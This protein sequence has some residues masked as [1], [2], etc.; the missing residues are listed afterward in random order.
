MYS[1]MQPFFRPELADL[2]GKRIDVLIDF[3]MEG[4][5]ENKPRWCQGEVI[6]VAE[7]CE[8]TVMVHWDPMSDVNDGDQYETSLQKLLPS[9]WN[10]D[11]EGAWRMD[12]TL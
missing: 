9:L 12:V 10:K 2:I 11:R 8:P 4:D 5:E 3:V 7:K 1:R 6:E